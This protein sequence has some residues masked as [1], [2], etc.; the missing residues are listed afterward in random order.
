MF[1]QRLVL[2]FRSTLFFYFG[3]HVA[4]N[5][6]ACNEVER[7]RLVFNNYETFPVGHGGETCPRRR[8]GVNKP[9]LHEKECP[10]QK[11]FSVFRLHSPQ[12]PII[13]RPPLWRVFFRP[14]NCVCTSSRRLNSPSQHS[15]RITESPAST[16]HHITSSHTGVKKPPPK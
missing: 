14:A 5:V 8:F 15:P 6:A 7:V 9:N 4:S 16:N 13:F 10:S 2:D 3:P 11:S 12:L 1:N